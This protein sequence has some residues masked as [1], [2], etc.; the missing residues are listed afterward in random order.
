MFSVW[1]F[2]VNLCLSFFLYFFHSIRFCCRSKLLNFH[3]NFFFLES[4]FSIS[5]AFKLAEPWIHRSFLEWISKCCVCVCMCVWRWWNVCYQIKIDLSIFQ[6]FRPSLFSLKNINK[7]KLI[8]SV[9]SLCRTN[10]ELWIIISIFQFQ[11][12]DSPT[13]ALTVGGMFAIN[14]FYAYTQYT[15]YILQFLVNLGDYCHENWNDKWDLSK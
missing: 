6:N 9:H 14:E 2:L 8:G 5:P 13:L 4:S 1:P 11:I 12:N 15:V 7:S 10:D 3:Y